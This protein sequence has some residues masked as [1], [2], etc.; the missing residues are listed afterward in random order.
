MPRLK[1]RPPRM[2]RNRN[3]AVV[4]IDGQT[5]RLGQWGSDEAREAY[6]RLIA[7]WLV[8]GRK[9]PAPEPEDEPVTVTELVVEYLRPARRRYDRGDLVNIEAGLKLM[10]QLGQD[11]DLRVRLPLGDPHRRPRLRLLDRLGQGPRGDDAGVDQDGS[12]EQ[13]TPAGRRPGGRLEE[14]YGAGSDCLDASPSRSTGGP[15]L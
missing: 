3:T 1:N 8:N 13:R 10:R 12:G 11:L 9:L 2:T 4:Y 5:V 7:E 6:D 14:Y 15:W